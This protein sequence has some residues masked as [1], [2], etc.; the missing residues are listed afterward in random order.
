M[1]F[2]NTALRHTH[3]SPLGLDHQPSTHRVGSSCVILGCLS[4]I[5]GLILIGAGMISETE[6]TVYFGIGIINLGVGIFL[7]SF[8]C[9]YTKLCVCYNNWAYR[10]RETPVQDEAPPCA[11]IEMKATVLSPEPAAA[12]HMRPFPMPVT[13]VSNIGIGQA[14]F[15]SSPTSVVK[16]NNRF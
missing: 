10:P 6:K 14:T 3:V 2:T 8:V 4:T 1:F 11:P 13:I 9:F 5:F 7:T 16:A 15:A 12:T